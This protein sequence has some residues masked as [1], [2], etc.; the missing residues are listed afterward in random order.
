MRSIRSP[1]A[2]SAGEIGLFGK[3]EDKVQ[4][5]QPWGAVCPDEGC[6][7]CGSPCSSALVNDG[8]RPPRAVSDQPSCP[9]SSWPPGR[10]SPGCCDKVF[11]K[12]PAAAFQRGQQLR[13][14]SSSRAASQGAAQRGTSRGAAAWLEPVPLGRCS[15]T[16]AS[17]VSRRRPWTRTSSTLFLGPDTDAGQRAHT[18]GQL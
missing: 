10:W 2:A 9:Q 14:S 17:R 12:P 4:L 13:S 15:E 18:R 16:L 11:V 3:N 5:R 1:G 8:C 6:W 7:R